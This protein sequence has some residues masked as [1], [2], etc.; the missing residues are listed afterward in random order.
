VERPFYERYPS[1]YVEKDGASIFREDTWLSEE[2]LKYLP[3]TYFPVVMQVNRYPRYKNKRSAD[4]YVKA[5]MDEAHIMEHPDW[6]LPVPNQDAAYK[7]FGGYAKDIPFMTERQVRAMNLAWEWT[8]Q[9][10]YPYMGG[11]RVRGVEEVIPDLDKNT[12]SGYPFNVIY[13]KKKD[14]FEKDP[15]IVQWLKSD[16]DNLL[17]E[18]YTFIF[19]CSLK[20]EI[21]PEVKTKMNK[22]RTFTAGAVDGTVHGNRLFADMNE[23]MNAGYLKSSSG[24][25][26]SPLKGNWDRLYRKLNIFRNGYALDESQYDASL[27]AYL[28]WGCAQC[29]W[30]MLRKE[31]QTEENLQR[32]KVYYRNLVNSLVLTPEGV[33]VM[34]LGGNP[35]GS[36]NTIND[37][38]LIL[39]TLLAYAW[40]MLSDLPD[41]LEFE[42][43][44]SKILVGDDNTWT[45]SDWG[46]TF[47]NAKTIIPVWSEIGVITTTDDME[48]RSAKD[49]D[50]LSATTI[51]YLGKAIPVYNRGKLM[52]SLLYAETE[53]QSP[54]FTLLRAAAL[55]Q[56]GW[57]DT[58]FRQFCREFISW[59]LE[60][61]D[62][63]CAED[64]DWIQAKSG[65]LSDERLADLYLGEDV[66]CYP[67]SLGQ[68]VYPDGC[69]CFCPHQ[70]ENNY[71]ESEKD[72]IKPDKMSMQK[73][74]K[75]RS[76]RGKG[77]KATRQQKW[78]PTLDPRD[79]RFKGQP[80]PPG[81]GKRRRNRRGRGGASNNTQ[82]QNRNVKRG[83]MRPNFGMRGRVKRVPL[84]REQ[85]S[86][87]VSATAWTLFKSYSINPGQS[88][89]PVGSVESQQWQKYRFR[90]FKVI[91]EPIVNEFNTNND[92]AGQVIIGF[93]PDA[94]DQ[95]PASFAQAINMKPVATG[96]PCDKI[97]L[98]VP[99]QILQA[100][101]DAHFV[102][103][104]LLPGGADIKTYDIGLVNISV[105]GCGTNGSTTIGNIYFEYEMDLEEQQ[106][107]LNTNAPVNNQVAYFETTTTESFSTGVRKNLLFA[108]A[109]ANG[110]GIVNTAGSMALPPGNYLVDIWC[111]TE[112]SANEASAMSIIP[113]F[114]GVSLIKGSINPGE[115][116]AGSGSTEQL[117]TSW[118]GYVSCNSATANA[119]TCS[120]SIVGA[121][122][123]LTAAAGCRI[124]AI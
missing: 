116:T 46:H 4:I 80:S 105:T 50:F 10:F 122:G 1:K 74:K 47:Y 34:K 56:I 123:T 19:T 67:Q 5:F 6:G 26:M 114:N 86:Q 119:L 39:Y 72:Q 21:R 69:I 113:S 52:T 84:M 66:L 24:V 29:R 14:L 99:R 68:H 48:P 32:I 77:A 63:L 83:N 101:V 22:I 92:G 98:V 112:D 23:R 40:I 30:K 115:N 44:T 103:H 8:E 20:E 76:R 109:T 59:L 17:D 16:W 93:D 64:L 57:S 121:A 100:K 117:C 118:S 61:F 82:F 107:L 36:V 49:L 9:Q 88:I 96:R 33:L 18:N 37:N 108:T 81:Q 65:I 90:S 28:M 85:I 12:S 60:R 104:G 120:L 7:S 102:R 45:V 51:F 70:Y 3:V 13:P 124:V 73:T 75:S 95:A 62:E 111:E 71:Q 87:P 15:E 55:L 97:V 106:V 31:D 35:S 110:L 58:Q 91:Y 89:F 94:S 79:V 42:A 54:A 11:A 53:K 2:H 41:Y 25:G 43:N 27:R 78:D 38:T